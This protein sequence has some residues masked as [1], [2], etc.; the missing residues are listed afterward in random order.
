MFKGKIFITL[1]IVSFLFVGCMPQNN[2]PEES[3][4]TV[5][6]TA[7]TDPLAQLTPE[8]K[9]EYNEILQNAYKLFLWAKYDDALEEFESAGEIAKTPDVYFNIATIHSKRKGEHQKAFNN[10]LKVYQMDPDYDFGAE[11]ARGFTLGLLGRGMYDDV[12]KW[13]DIAI[14]KWYSKGEP[15]IVYILRA[16][17]FTYREMYKYDKAMELAREYMKEYPNDPVI[18]DSLGYFLDFFEKNLEADNH[19]PMIMYAKT[20]TWLLPET[21]IKKFQE[22]LEKYPKTKLKDEIY[23]QIGRIYGSDENLYGMHD[24][25]KEIEYMNKLIEECPDSPYISDAL[26]VIDT[27]NFRYGKIDKKPG[28]ADQN[29]YKQHRSKPLPGMEH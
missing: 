21:K 2:Q 11:F 22:I 27:I 18:R 9:K 15:G 4:S 5:K 12:L 28:H 24:F 25:E 26:R 10:F 7:K 6:S 3:S 1:L 16:R 29:W 20:R 13:S 14:R 17:V 19:E 23:Y 8:K